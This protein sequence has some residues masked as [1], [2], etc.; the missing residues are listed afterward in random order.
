[1]NI[2]F[3]LA[4]NILIKKFLYNRVFKKWILLHYI[5][6]IYKDLIYEEYTLRYI[7]IKFLFPF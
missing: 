7:Q 3:R 1:M 2:I 4:V 6:N 5:C